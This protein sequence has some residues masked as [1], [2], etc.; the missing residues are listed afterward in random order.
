MNCLGELFGY[1]Q[2]KASLFLMG[3]VRCWTFF[4][5]NHCRKF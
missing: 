4:C 5:I 3:F 1:E 2:D